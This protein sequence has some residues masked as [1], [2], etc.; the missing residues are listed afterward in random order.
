LSTLL[1]SLLGLAAFFLLMSQG[2]PIAFSFAI[3]GCVGMIL[4]KGVGPGLALVGSSPY[5]WASA[6]ALLPVPLFILMGQFVFHSGVSTELYETAHKWAGRLPG[7]LALATTLAST[8]FAACS[9]VSMAGAAT[10]ASVAYPEME[11]YHYDPKLST[12]CITAGGSLSCLIPPSAAFI[13]YGALTETSVGKLF[14]AGILPGILL[15]CLYLGLILFMARRNPRLA[16]PG[17]SYTMREMLASLKGTIAVLIL[18]AMVIGGLFAGVF[19]PSEA[20]SMGAFGAFVIIAVRRRLTFKT[21]VSAVR[22]SIRTTCFI[23]TITIGAMIFSNFLAVGGFSTMFRNWVAALPVSPHIVLIC[24]L[25]IYIPL[26]MVMDGLAMLLLTIPIVYPLILTFGF[27]PI[28]FGIIMTLVVEMALIT[29]PVGLNS[30]VVHGVTRV[31]LE[32]VFRGVMPFFLMMVLCLAL[33]YAFP[34]ISLFLPGIM[35]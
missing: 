14:V 24:I 20:G 31:P 32:T 27:D 15:A 8:G 29:P 26:G 5:T 23:L 6:G 17:P 22:D 33:L 9:G 19:T 12:G 4:L 7:G 16:P 18:F 3:V 2:V 34:Q 21:L 1:I 13:I 25:L 11:A 35:S 10:M 30:Y 28:W